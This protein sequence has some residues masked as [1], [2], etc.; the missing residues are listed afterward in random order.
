MN[1]RGRFLSRLLTVF[2]AVA[3]SVAISAPPATAGD[4]R[5]LQ[6]VALGDSY[7]AGGALTS[8]SQSADGYP[9]L[10]DSLKHV[11]L[12]ADASCSGATTLDVIDTQL[13][14]LDKWTTL[15]TLT[16]G[17]NNLGVANVAAACTAVP[18]TN[19]QAAIDYALSQLA[20]LAGSLADVYEAVAAAAPRAKILVTGYPYLFGTTTPPCSPPD[21]IMLQINSATTALNQTIKDTVTAAQ[22]AGLNIQY[23]DVTGAFSIHGINCLDPFINVTGQDAF[24]PNEAGYEA[25]AA[26]LRAALP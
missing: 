22:I 21:A 23:V 25:Y 1:T 20:P 19:C 9:E 15:V 4:S 11:H 18:P 17:A 2:I 14:A 3:A 7:A 26:A 24:H 10:L 5:T 16:V 6:Y 13:S 8:C 12:R